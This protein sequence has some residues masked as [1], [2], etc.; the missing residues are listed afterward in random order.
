VKEQ[1]FSPRGEVSGNCE[2]V[3]CERKIIKL[4]KKTFPF[5]LFFPHS[6]IA[7]ILKFFYF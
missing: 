3:L 7:I 1:W 4:K 6:T 2:D 5:K